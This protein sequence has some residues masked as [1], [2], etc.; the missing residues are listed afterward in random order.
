MIGTQVC[1]LSGP[2]SSADS[3]PWTA[4]GKM[5]RE[6][7]PVQEDAHQAVGSAH[8]SGYL[9]TFACRAQRLKYGQ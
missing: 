9:H 2:W 1:W 6:V 4:T 5:S 7:S 8:S 3:A